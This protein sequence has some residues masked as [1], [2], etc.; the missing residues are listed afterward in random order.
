MDDYTQTAREQGIA[1]ALRDLTDGVTDLVRYQAELIRVEARRETSEAGARGAKLLMFAGVA[2]VG[3]LLLNAALLSL[4]F[5]VFGT[6][7]GVIVAAVL[8]IGH[9]GLGGLGIWRQLRGFE[10]QRERLESTAKSVSGRTEWKQI[11]GPD[12]T[13]TRP[14]EMAEAS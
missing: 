10:K 8:A 2:A 5:A 4:A 12:S 7:I 11:E 3:Y 9:L 13:P 1:A 14:K 6:I